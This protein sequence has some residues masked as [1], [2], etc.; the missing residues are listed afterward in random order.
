MSD[1]NLMNRL[2]NASN[3]YQGKYKRVLCVCS[4][5]LLRSPT[6]AYVLSQEPYNFNTRAAGLTKEFALVPVDRVLLHWADEIVCMNDQQ[7]EQLRDM[8][9]EETP[10]VVLNIE[11]NY[12]YRDPELIEAIKKAYDATEAITA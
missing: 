11:D 8:L 7:A 4:A 12:R 2:A 6:A 9:E 10:I 5:G 3:I 1:P